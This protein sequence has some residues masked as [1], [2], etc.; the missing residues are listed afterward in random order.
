MSDDYQRGYD[1]GRSGAPTFSPSSA[2]QA[3]WGGYIAGQADRPAH[4]PQSA[5][6]TGASVFGAW[7]GSGPTL[8]GSIKA[9]GVGGALIGGFIGFTSG[10]LLYIPIGLVVG[11]IAGAAATVALWAIT[12]PVRK[13]FRL[14]PILWPV[15]LGGGYAVDNAL[16]PCPWS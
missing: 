3:A 14:L 8:K 6:S 10:T 7:V 12:W 13:L 15:T 2:S 11:Y 9:F 5:S 16:N 1:A 4:M